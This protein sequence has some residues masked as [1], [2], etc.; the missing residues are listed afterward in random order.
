MLTSS[1]LTLASSLRISAVEGPE[2][3]P[4]EAMIVDE[5]LAFLPPPRPE[6]R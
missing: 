6:A 5:E 4:P 3:A 1:L 2:G